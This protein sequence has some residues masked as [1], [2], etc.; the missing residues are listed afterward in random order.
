MPRT[1][2]GRGRYCCTKCQRIVELHFLSLAYCI[3]CDRKMKP[4]KP[5]ET[6]QPSLFDRDVAAS[7]GRR[8]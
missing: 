3:P 8:S 7:S 5:N 1:K 6:P 4:L 2:P